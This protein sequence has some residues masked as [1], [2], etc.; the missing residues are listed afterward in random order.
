MKLSEIQITKA[1]DWLNLHKNHVKKLTMEDVT[2]YAPTDNED[3]NNPSLWKANHWIWFFTLH[4]T[5]HPL[6][7]TMLRCKNQNVKGNGLTRNRE[8]KC[9]NVIYDSYTIVDDNGKLESYHKSFF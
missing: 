5:I 2:P 6:I 9:L 8:Y 4:T 7:G 3:K 1:H